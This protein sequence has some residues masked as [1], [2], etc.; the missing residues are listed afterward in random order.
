MNNFG[1]GLILSFTDNASSGMQN[2]TR[3]FQDLNNATSNFSQANNVD[4]ALLQISY[5]AGIVG[6]DLYRIG[7]GITSMFTSAIQK[8]TEVGTTVATARSQLSTLYQS[9]E[10]GAQK[11]N[12]I[13]DY[14]KSSIFNFEDLIPSVIMLKANGIEA[15]E[16]IASSAYL[17]SDG[18]EG[19]RQTL[20]DYAADL[21]AFNPQMKNAYGTGVQAAMGALNEYIAEGNAMSLKRGASLDINQLIGEDTAGT[22]EERSRQV[23]DLI[24]QLGMVG[25][26]ANLAG[27]PMQ[28]LSNVS[29]IFFN[30]MS[31][32]SDSGVFEKYSELIAKFTD[33]LFSIPDSE[34]KQIAEVI[35]GALVD[36]MSPLEKVIDLGI[37]AVDWL[38]D[39]VKVNPE[40]V[41]TTIKTVAVGGAFLLL[42]GIVLKLASSLGLLRITISGL[43]KGSALSSGLSMLGLFKN[44]MM[45]I[46]PLI[47]LVTLLKL[48]WDRNFLGIQEVTKNTLATVVDSI[49]LVFDAFADNTLSEE[50]FIRAKELGILPFIEG[51]LQLKYHWGFFVD[52]FKKGLDSFFKTLG[53]ILVRL[54]I[55][56]VDV[57]GAGELIVAL[58]EKMTA[59][60]MTDTWENLGEILGEVTGWILVMI[61]LLPVVLKG[62]SA[63]TTLI[64][65]AW[66]ALKFVGTVLGKIW[67]V[68]SLVGRGAKWVWTG[69][70]SIG[71]AL[72]GLNFASIGASLSSIGSHIATFF[73]TIA[74]GIGSVLTAIGSVVGL[75][76]WAVGLII[77]AIVAL[78]ATI[79]IFWD[80]IKAFFG[81]IGNAIKDF[82]VNAFN[83][84]MEI[85]I[86]Q[87]IVEMLKKAIGGIIDFI[88]GIIEPVIRIFTTVYE[89]VKSFIT[90]AIAIVVGFGQLVW[91]IISGVFNIISSVV[92]AV[93]N[94]IKSV[95]GLIG[96]IFYAIYAVI[97][98]IVLAVIWVFQQLWN[99]IK[100]GLDFVW[101]IFST[102]F[103][104][105]YNNII[106][107]IISAIST[108]FKWLCTNVFSPV[109]DFIKGIFDKIADVVEWIGD[110]FSKVFG[111]VKDFLLGVFKKIDE[112]V[113][114]I[115]D[116]IADAI[117][118]IGDTLGKVVDKVGGFFGG[119]GDFFMDVGDEL[120]EA[121]GLATGGYVKTTGIAMLHP[122]EVVVND[123]LTQRLGAFLNDYDMAKFN[124]SPLI[125]N[126]VIATDDYA[127]REDNVLIPPIPIPSPENDDNNSD[128]NSPM[129]A[130]VN[131]S[132]NNVEDNSSQSE[133]D[134]SSDNRVI[135]ESGSV[136]IQV[137]NDCKF[138]EAELLAMSDKLM[139]IMARKLQLRQL[140]TRK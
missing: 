75:P 84:L 119:I 38:R 122:N 20:M 86:V 49:K 60:G 58:I 137:G 82:F 99:G 80:E 105:I 52:G 1:L 71:T 135:F 47:A 126:D 101:N 83:K 110:K 74:S 41:Q 19:S 48:A 43:F 18:I 91:S 100:I 36:L 55:L 21:A 136:V 56:D 70:K 27:T 24:E 17:A 89:V 73:S 50:G 113:S 34:I 7:A 111:K 138:T 10:A 61:T 127:E 92:G 95:A 87:K 79:V 129:K 63:I 66:T 118:W 123:V 51:I 67:D 57:S 93:W 30:L 5:A 125:T 46:A 32:V 104:W 9:E 132:V 131:N 77:V 23:A 12:E 98:T 13:K 106:S 11:L 8:V 130:L 103:G 22:I 117:E 72:S 121:V 45:V 88:K 2:A 54:G 102:V 15:F 133:D 96:N 97:R 42:S 44:F 35:A 62:I 69:I 65:G 85:P 28:R 40:L 37:R 81:K 78:I 114:P 76:A 94:I 14:A 124:S 31:D 134:N 107:P 29:D 108:A 3:S 4:S 59:P 120:S 116:G 128:G 68:L 39:T 140:Q 115:L 53:D 112:F 6:D 25:M 33:Y 16:Q 109:G 90:N 26:T 64:R 139:S